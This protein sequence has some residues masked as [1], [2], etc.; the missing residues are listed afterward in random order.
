[1]IGIIMDF[2][3]F[4][5]SLFN[6]LFK[7]N[8][9][10]EI[11]KKGTIIVLV[12][13]VVLI[14]I[15]VFLFVL[16][17]NTTTE[18]TDF[19]DVNVEDWCYDAVTYLYNRGLIIGT[20]EKQFAPEEPATRAV[21]TTILYRLEGE[22]A[23][24]DVVTFH[25]VPWDQYYSNAVAWAASNKIVV[26]YDGFFYP[27]EP[28]TREQ[29]ALILYRYH[30]EYRGCQVTNTG[31]ELNMFIDWKSVSEYA[32]SSVAWAI[33]SG[34]FLDIIDDYTIMPEYTVTRAQVAVIFMRYCESFDKT[35]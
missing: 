20:G 28:I 8:K 31:S 30:K 22:P 12:I 4:F 5:I 25:D 33:Q 11:T 23:F 18:T 14:C 3:N 10:I 17:N 16:F 32:A 2:L 6:T 1:M 21:V 24:K 27:G 13:C 15:G 9:K 29:M 26:G 35:F 7:V 34:L 19:S